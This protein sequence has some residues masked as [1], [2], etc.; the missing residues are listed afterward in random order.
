M[1]LSRFGRISLCKMKT[2]L[3]INFLFWMF[4]N[5]LDEDLKDWQNLVNKLF[6]GDIRVRINKKNDG[7]NHKNGMVRFSQN[8]SIFYSESHEIYLTLKQSNILIV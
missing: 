6:N 8:K 2:I 4:S 1:R 3:K 5:L 7:I